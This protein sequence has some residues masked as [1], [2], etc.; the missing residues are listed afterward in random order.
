VKASSVGGNIES[1]VS[2]GSASYHLLLDGSGQPHFGDGAQFG[3]DAI[4]PDRVDDEQWHQ[5]IGTFDGTNT[6]SIYVDGQ[7]VNSI[8][9]AVPLIAGDTDDIWIGGDPDPG[10]FQIFD[11]LIDEVTLLT[12]ALSAGQIEQLFSV[13]TNTPAN[14]PNFISV[15]ASSTSPNGHAITFSWS[16]IPGQMYQV[17]FSRNLAQTT[18]SNLNGTIRASNTIT[19]VSDDANTDTQRFY[20]VILDP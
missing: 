18:W 13:A 11:G 17:Q 20:R 6:Q 8:T 16:S 2:H 12:N 4:G 10:E 19:T 14:P 5:L 1:I 3:G 7:I 15:S 9:N